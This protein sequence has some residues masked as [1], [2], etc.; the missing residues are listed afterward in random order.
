MLENKIKYT[1]VVNKK[2]INETHVILTPLLT[3]C[4]VNIPHLR[5]SFTS[6][7]LRAPLRAR[8]NRRPLI[9]TTILIITNPHKQPIPVS[10]RPLEKVLMPDVTEIVHAV[11]VDVTADC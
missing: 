1:V 7:H 5:D 9:I 10:E 8:H 11:A 3:C 6:R 4:V 2:P